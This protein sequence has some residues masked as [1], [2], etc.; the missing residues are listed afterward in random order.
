M[1]KLRKIS[2]YSTDDDIFI[3]VYIFNDIASLVQYAKDIKN[4]TIF[5]KIGEGL[6]DESFQKTR[7]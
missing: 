5:N 3:E 7:V 4:R 2:E 1:K 6:Y